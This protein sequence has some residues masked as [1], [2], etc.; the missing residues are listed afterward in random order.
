MMV[1]GLFSGK[2]IIVQDRS[3]FITVGQV[4]KQVFLSPDGKRRYT[5]EESRIEFYD[6]V[7]SQTYMD[8][9]AET[10]KTTLK[11]EKDRKE[12]VDYV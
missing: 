12:G 10:V 8:K 1:V 5:V 11:K 2:E 7:N 9:I 4:P 6:E 3:F